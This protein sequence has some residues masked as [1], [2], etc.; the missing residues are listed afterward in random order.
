M[1]HSF[2]FLSKLIQLAFGT[3]KDFGVRV[4]F[5]VWIPFTLPVARWR[6]R[7][8]VIESWHRREADERSIALHSFGNFDTLKLNL[9]GLVQ[10]LVLLDS[11]QCCLQFCGVVF[12]LLLTVHDELF[13]CFVPFLGV[14][15]FIWFVVPVRYISFDEF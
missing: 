6:I 3:N 12:Y 4:P 1:P 7:S 8:S 13:V 9:L 15:W 11:I 2:G 5:G 10:S 14:F